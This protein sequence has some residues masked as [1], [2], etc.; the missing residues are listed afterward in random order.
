MKFNHI[1]IIGLFMITSIVSSP[2]AQNQPPVVSNVHAEQ[3]TGTKFVDISYTL[4]DEDSDTF[5]V[6]IQVSR[7]GGGEFDVPVKSLSGDVGYGVT[8]G[9]KAVVWNAGTDFPEEFGDNFQVKV[10]A[11]DAPI[12]KM[13][14][15]AGGTFTMGSDNSLVQFKP[16]HSVTLSPYYMSATEI[17]NI[18]YKL[19]C[20]ATN[21][22]YP[23]DPVSNY[24][25]DYPDYPVVNVTWYD[26][27]E[28][29]NW[30]SIQS[31]LTPCYNTSNWSCNFANNG[32]RLPTEAQWE[33]AARGGLSGMDYP[34]G[35][36][37]RSDSVNYQGYDGALDTLMANFDTGRGPMPVASFDSTGF[38]IY[39]IAGNVSE[40][41]N[42]WY[43][44][45]YYYM[46]PAV[47]PP[48]PDSGSDKVKRGGDWHNS[49]EY[50]RCF[51]RDSKNPGSTIRTYEIGFRIVRKK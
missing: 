25:T 26:A 38:G 3:R 48:G 10:I 49:H 2:R 32:F 4:A 22:D 14:P 9:E 47:D 15:I 5:F 7:D 13:L 18:Q 6:A 28:Y 45:E 51:H 41:C 43:N 20:D 8:K 37:L 33:R 30:L 31:G 17:T 19:F 36:D 44:S 21:R 50:L 35:N 40:W 12:G 29:C 46:S 11:S 23:V 27:V 1:I 16:A 39:D 24:F 34:W 42:D